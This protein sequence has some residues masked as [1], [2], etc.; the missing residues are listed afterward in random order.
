M[1]LFIISLFLSYLIGS[2]PTGYLI[3]KWF[4]K[5]DIREHGSGNPGATNVF[6]VVGTTAGAITL[7]IDFFKGFI[8][9][10]TAIHFF[11]NQLILIVIIGLFSIAGHNWTL[12]LKF[13]GGKGVITSG[14]VFMAILPIP[15]TIAFT[16]FLITFF[17]T[18]HVSI[19]SMISAISLPISVWFI[20]G[21]Y[22]LTTVSFFCAALIIFLHRSNISRLIKGKELKI[23]LGEKNEK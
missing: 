8:P 15:T 18:K 7:I 6:R 14:G 3:S 5:I 16:I 17:A 19:G 10:I 9:V 20:N 13:R 4:K 11:P 12:F 22:F 21:S 1:M 23:S 2:I